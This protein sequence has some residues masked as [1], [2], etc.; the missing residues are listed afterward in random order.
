MDGLKDGRTD[1][2]TAAGELGRGRLSGGSWWRET[3]WA[4]LI[5]VAGD[6]RR[7]LWL[8]AK[9]AMSLSLWMRRRIDVGLLGR[10]G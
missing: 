1:G 6:A 7:W 3:Q 8:W 10:S 4:V 2:R 5:V 9:V